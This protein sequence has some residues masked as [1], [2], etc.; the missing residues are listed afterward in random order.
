MNRPL[1]LLL[2]ATAALPLAAQPTYTKEV[3]RIMQEKCHICHQANDIAPFEL[4]SYDDAVTYSEDIQRVLTAKTMPPW[5]P[6][7]GHGTFKN[8][9]GLTDDERATVL[10]WINSGMP[11]GD[12]SDMPDPLPPKGDWQQ[13]EPD[14]VYAMAQPFDVPRVKD[15]YRCFVMPTGLDA[16]RWIQ[17]AEVVPGNRQV[18]HHVLL[19]IDETGVSDKLDGKD[20]KPG[21]DC[22]GGPGFDLTIGGSLGAWV[23]GMRPQVLPEGTAIALPKNSRVV[24]Q[25][26]YNNPGGL[27]VSDVTRVGLYNSTGPVSKHFLYLPI[28]PVPLSKLVVPANVANTVFTQTYPVPPFLDAQLWQ[29]GPHMHLLGRQVSV[30]VD[31]PKKQGTVPL[32]LI[33]NWDFNWQGL[34]SLTEPVS[35]PAGS[36]IRLTCS[37]DNTANNPRNPN[38]PVQTVKWGEGTTDEMCIGFLGIT[39]NAENLQGTSAGRLTRWRHQ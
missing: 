33:D 4:S 16:D 5:K 28:A 32:I 1:L 39:L 18:V 25:V 15:L 8:N 7:E 30:D 9:F 29:V 26:H 20:G 12:P 11:M 37:Y 19:F 13:G 22:F 27:Q 24:M 14:L 2:L 23:P 35:V 3:S 36:T 31:L 21:Y 6:V 38:D 17:S 34:Y 10:S